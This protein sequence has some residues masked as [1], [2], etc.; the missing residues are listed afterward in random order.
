M[1][2][3]PLTPVFAYVG[4]AISLLSLLLQLHLGGLLAAFIIGFATGATALY[5]ATRRR[6]QCLDQ[7]AD[8]C[9]ASRNPK[10]PISQSR[11]G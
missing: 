11:G 3:I 10:P 5:A 1:K 6:S 4:F 8:R 7:P 9:G 2:E